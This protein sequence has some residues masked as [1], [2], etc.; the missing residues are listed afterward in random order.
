MRYPSPNLPIATRSLQPAGDFLQ[1][2]LL[3]ADRGSKYLLPI[4]FSVAHFRH[5]A[6]D[7]M[8]TRTFYFFVFEGLVD[9]EA[10]YALAAVNNPQ[11]QRSPSRY[12]VKTLG[13]SRDAVT[14]IGGLR[15]TPDVSI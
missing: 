11:F 7:L 10:S 15:I 8:E 1:L 6:K 12:R 5:Q 14:S 2:R 3:G 13:Q 4:Y 9:Y